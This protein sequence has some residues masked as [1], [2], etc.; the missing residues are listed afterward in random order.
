[1]TVTF[2]FDN[3]HLPPNP[4]LFDPFHSLPPPPCIPFHFAFSFVA[5]RAI[6]I[7]ELEGEI[8]PRELI[9]TGVL[10]LVPGLIVNRS[11]EYGMAEAFYREI[12]R[13]KNHPEGIVYIV[14]ISDHSHSTEL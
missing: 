5:W 13:T 2:E 8:A 4:P 14:T 9:H 11:C 12:H 6:R 7:V 3:K 1:M 10:Q